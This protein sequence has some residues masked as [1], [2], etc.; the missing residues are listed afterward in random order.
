MLATILFPK[1]GP[2]GLRRFSK[3][4]QTAQVA[5]LEGWQ[6]SHF[7]ARTLVFVS[8][9]SVITL[10]YLADPAVLRALNLAPKQ[11]DT[12]VS[13]AD[14]LWPRIGERPQQIRFTADDLTP[15]ADPPPLAADGPLHPDY[16]ARRP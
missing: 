10:A 15:P 16:E 3:L 4:S 8:L 5:Y 6:T 11:V 2:S 9:R 13:E 14:L 12:P 1:G 7:F